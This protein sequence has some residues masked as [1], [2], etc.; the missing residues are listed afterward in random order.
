MVLLDTNAVLFDAL[1]PHRLSGPALEALESPSG[2]R[3]FAVAGISLWEVSMLA[4]HGRL[5]L[6][7]DTESFLLDV[8][9]ARSLTILPVTAKIAALSSAL[10][11]HG[12]PSDRLIA[13]T[14]VAHQ[15]QLI[16]S[17]AKLQAAR[18]LDVIW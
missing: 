10:E 12:D 11:L 6:P 7:T 2:P 18:F 5:E 15:L 14:A 9:A 1:A 8:I 13:A 16:T 17:D 4:Q 3:A